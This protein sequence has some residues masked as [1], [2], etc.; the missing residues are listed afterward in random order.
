MDAFYERL[1]VRAATFDE[2]LS[3]DFEP[4]PGQKTE[5]N[6]AAERLAAWC[7]SCASGDWALFGRRL[8]RDGLAFD[9][10]LTRF[11][12]VRR[13]SSV[14]PPA[15]VIDAVWIMEALQSSEPV[16]PAVDAEMSAFEAPVYAVGETSQ[17]NL[18]V[19]RRCADA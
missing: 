4:L 19:G 11:A 15:W 13:K 7:R 9:E 5:T 8:A 2:L 6:L 12:T 14:A 1:L 18:M 3:D 10:I 16:V 17:R